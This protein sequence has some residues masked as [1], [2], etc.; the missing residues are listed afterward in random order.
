MACWGI[1]GA[2]HSAFL[3]LAGS[4]VIP[5]CIQVDHRELLSCSLGRDANEI[6]WL[7]NGQRYSDG[8]IRRTLSYSEVQVEG[9]PELNG[10]R[11]DCRASF[12]DD[13][14]AE[15]ITSWVIVVLESKSD[16]TSYLTEDMQACSDTK[17]SS[18]GWGLPLSSR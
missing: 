1:A 16:R 10:S 13:D 5:V 17:N 18:A 4:Q 14:E 11:F 9:S 2:C 3:S 7:K 12:G 15:V 8:I 6:F